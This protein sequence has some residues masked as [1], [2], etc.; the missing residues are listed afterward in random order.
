MTR[1]STVHLAESVGSV[2]EEAIAARVTPGAV[3]AVSAPGVETTVVAFGRLSYAAEAERVT[4]ETVYDLASITKVFTALVVLRLASKGILCLDMSLGGMLGRARP[5]EFADR[6]LVS[7][8]SH[9]AGFQAWR[10]LFECGERDAVIDGALTGPAGAEGVELYSDL[11]YIAVG[12]AI[13]AC[14]G[15][16]LG[17]LVEA[18]VLAPLGVSRRVGYRGVNAVSPEVA[19]TERCPWRKRVLQGEVHDE[20]AWAMGG[21]AGHA[22]LFGSAGA[23]VEVG[24]A[25]VESYRGDSRWLG[26]EAMRKMVAPREGGSHRIGWDGRSKSGSTSGRRFSDESFGHL[27]FTGT[28]IWCDPSRELVVVLL[29]NRVHPSRE[30]TGINALRRTVHDRVY[31]AVFA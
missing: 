28:S 3:L 15:R 7:V 9:R 11:G 5:T 29:T 13:E 16:S 6:S 21:V 19:P 20:N 27:G 4:A 12:A 1:V 17:D 25:A 24:R 22:G 23:L 18:E 2:I 31:D 8:L 26:C 14:T 10:A 30:G